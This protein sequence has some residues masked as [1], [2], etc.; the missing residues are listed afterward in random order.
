MWQE[1]QVQS[2]GSGEFGVGVMLDVDGGGEMGV[3]VG[4]WLKKF[5]SVGRSG[6]RGEKG[7]TGWVRG[8]GTG[9]LVWRRGGMFAAMEPLERK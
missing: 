9:G 5:L 6:L 8:E 1:W 2:H 7:E 3:G 4:G